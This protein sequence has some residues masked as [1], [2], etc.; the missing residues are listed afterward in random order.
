MNKLTLEKQICDCD[1]L[2]TWNMAFDLRPESRM[3]EKHYGET[4]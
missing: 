4:S 1:H 3:C 2:I